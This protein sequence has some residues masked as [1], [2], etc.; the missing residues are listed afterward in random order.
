ME[1]K[2]SC[3]GGRVHAALSA[4]FASLH[5]LVFAVPCT[6]IAQSTTIARGRVRGSRL[7]VRVQLRNFQ[8]PR[9]TGSVCSKLGARWEED[10]T[11]GP[12]KSAPQSTSAQWT[13]WLTARPKGQWH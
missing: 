4:S 1:A 3:G 12:H 8:S 10:L 11:Y 7:R 9:A 2:D 5:E 6:Y 13:E